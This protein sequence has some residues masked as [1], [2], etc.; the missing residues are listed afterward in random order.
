VGLAAGAAATD[1]AAQARRV[2]RSGGS[3]AVAARSGTMQIVDV[4]A[5]QV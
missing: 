2:C 5:S 4:G 3:V 1:D